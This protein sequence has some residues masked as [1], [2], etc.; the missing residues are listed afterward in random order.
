MKRLLN[1]NTSYSVGRALIVKLSKGLHT[2]MTE[3]WLWTWEVTKG[4]QR[5]YYAQQVGS[6]SWTTSAYIK[7]KC[8]GS[9]IMVL[10]KAHRIDL[11]WEQCS[12]HDEK[13][14]MSD[15]RNC[16]GNSSCQDGLVEHMERGFLQD[17]TDNDLSVRIS[18]FKK[19]QLKSQNWW[20]RG[21]AEGHSGSM[22][23]GELLSLLT[24][25]CVCVDSQCGWGLS[26]TAYQ[27]PSRTP[28]VTVGPEGPL[29][30]NIIAQ[31]MYLSREEWKG[32]DTSRKRRHSLKNY[33]N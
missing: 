3:Y 14:G 29:L 22:L 15:D 13:A 31:T 24:I 33:D 26:W 18:S 27:M 28:K 30:I 1:G 11:N 9:E 20:P 21:W 19:C 12:G 5:K 32:R 6:T 4:G 16:I 25:C 23:G 7:W 10:N 8:M 17:S 2:C